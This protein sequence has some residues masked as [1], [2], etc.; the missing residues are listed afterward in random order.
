MNTA[1]FSPG[2]IVRHRGM[3]QHIG[4]VSAVFADRVRVR[5]GAI[6]W[7]GDA[8]ASD[9]QTIARERPF[10]ARL[11]SD[12][13]RRRDDEAI[14]EAPV[15]SAGRPWKGKRAS[16]TKTIPKFHAA[17]PAARGAAPKLESMNIRQGRC[18]MSQRG[19]EMPSG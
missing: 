2:D 12:G 4:R 13:G 19:S 5:W 8:S 10:L 15:N 1:K 17:E 18:R 6:R 14:R 7:I 3:P 16:I 9:L 11:I